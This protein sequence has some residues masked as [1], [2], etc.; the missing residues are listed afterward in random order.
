MFRCR[1]FEF[2]FKSNTAHQS[3]ESPP[4]PAVYYYIEQSPLNKS[5]TFAV[6]WIILLFYISKVYNSGKIQ[7]PA[8]TNIQV[9][10]WVWRYNVIVKKKYNID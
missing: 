8:S 9:C 3:T 1:R 4:P 10:C 6:K 2:Y 7:C 5:L